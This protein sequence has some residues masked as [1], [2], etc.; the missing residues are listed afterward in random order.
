MQET[1]QVLTYRVVWRPITRTWHAS[2]ARAES[3]RGK[4][5]VR[6]SL[7]DFTVGLRPKPAAQ[8]QQI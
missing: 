8:P 7:S 4:G 3:V 6:Q 2:D 5:G 1:A